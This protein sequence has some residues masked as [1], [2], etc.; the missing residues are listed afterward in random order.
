MPIQVTC[1]GCHTRFKVGDQHA[2]KTGACPK[3]KAPIDIPKL[4]DEVIIHAPEHEA[5]AVDA[6]G[7]N[8]LKP[9]KRKEAKFNWNLFV[10]ISGLV[11]L[12]LATTWLLGRSELTDEQRT[13]V[14][15]AGAILLGPPLSY[16]GYSFLRDDEMGVYQGTSVL[17]R[18]VICGLVYALLWG[19]YVYVGIQLFGTNSFQAGLE[20]VQVAGLAAVVMALGTFCA[21][22]SFDL[23]PFSAFFHYALYFLVSI[24]LRTVMALPFLPGMN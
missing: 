13:W 24:I 5:G 21:Y 14:L 22:V 8:V 19:V 6:K 10:A 17:V 4:E 2:G 1:P 7:R 11:V 20:M 23:E 12:C 3:C 15:T 18:S 9:L 16:A